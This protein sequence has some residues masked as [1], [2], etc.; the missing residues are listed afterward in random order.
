ME[1]ESFMQN[2]IVENDLIDF[3]SNDNINKKRHRRHRRSSNKPQDYENQHTQ[4]NQSPYS[5][6]MGFQQTRPITTQMATQTQ[7]YQTT[8]IGGGTLGFVTA[9]DTYTYADNDGYQNF[10]IQN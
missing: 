7:T 2:T 5:R 6:Q 1:Q 3:H 9:I 4:M 8:K 10:G